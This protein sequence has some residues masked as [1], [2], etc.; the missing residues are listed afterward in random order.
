MRGAQQ[1]EDLHISF[2]QFS[3]RILMFCGVEG[4]SPGVKQLMA[5]CQLR[6]E[7]STATVCPIREDLTWALI[8]RPNHINTGLKLE[9]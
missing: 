3:F 2:P 7:K 5:T 8:L 9:L 4:Q 6:M 1:T